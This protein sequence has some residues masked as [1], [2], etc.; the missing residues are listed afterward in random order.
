MNPLKGG[1]HRG[2]NA[3]RR[4]G[5]PQI[6]AA[7]AGDKVINWRRIPFPSHTDAANVDAVGPLV[8]SHEAKRGLLMR[9]LEGDITHVQH[10]DYPLRIH[11]T[12]GHEGSDGLMRCLSPQAIMR[13]RRVP[14]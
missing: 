8:K 11:A 1:E 5:L 9:R 4:N 6:S 7:R 12:N 13:I 2:A 3:L 14:R 10:A